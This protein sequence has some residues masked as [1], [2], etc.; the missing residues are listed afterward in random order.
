MDNI[1]RSERPFTLW[2]ETLP[3]EDSARL[4]IRSQVGQV[5]A[6]FVWNGIEHSTRRFA[7]ASAAH[8]WGY[9]LREVLLR[10]ALAGALLGYD[11]DVLARLQGQCTSPS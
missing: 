11:A 2:F 5:E 3:S 7:D 9:E 4:V 10:D 8:A 6:V 1:S